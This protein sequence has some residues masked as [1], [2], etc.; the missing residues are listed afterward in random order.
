MVSG[1]GVLLLLLRVPFAMRTAGVCGRTGER[2]PGAVSRRNCAPPW[3][4]LRRGELQAWGALRHVRSTPAGVGAAGAAMAVVVT[5]EALR[6]P[7]VEWI[8][9]CSGV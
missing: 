7:P 6:G 8:G 2:W 3:R 9:R 4:L 1:A 5:R